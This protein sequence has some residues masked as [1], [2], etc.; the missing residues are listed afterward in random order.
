[1]SGGGGWTP[2]GTLCAPA[3]RASPENRPRTATLP[4][5]QSWLDAITA[6]PAAER[7][8]AVHDQHLTGLNTADEAAWNSGSWQAIPATTVTGTPIRIRDQLSAYAQDAITEV[9][10]Q[11]PGP[12]IPWELERFIAIAHDI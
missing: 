4:G 9:V 3:P 10:Y 11:P 6:H 2:A 1:V 7:H 5:G 12:D 8:L